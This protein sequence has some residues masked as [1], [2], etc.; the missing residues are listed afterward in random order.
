MANPKLDVKFFDSEKFFIYVKFTV[1]S[2]QKTGFIKYYKSNL[3]SVIV[4]NYILTDKFKDAYELDTQNDG[5]IFLNVAKTKTYTWL[6]NGVT[7][8]SME[9]I[10]FPSI[11][12]MEYLG[13]GDI[14]YDTRVYNEIKTLLNP[15]QELYLTQKY[16][17][18]WS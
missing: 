3:S 10:T 7:I 15:E 6:S 17:V 12:S 13:Y 9:V 2:V 1:N 11:I 16:G 18:V 14:D 4:E 8:D 5:Y